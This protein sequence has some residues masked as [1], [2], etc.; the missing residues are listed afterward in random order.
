MENENLETQLDEAVATEQVEQAANTTNTA[1]ELENNSN[2][3]EQEAN[4]AIEEP[5]TNAEPV[6]EEI[7]EP[8]TEEKAAEIVEPV[9]KEPSPPPPP[10]KPLMPVS[11]TT[12]VDKTA[13]LSLSRRMLRSR[14]YFMLI[15]AVLLIALGGL[16]W[17]ILASNEPTIALIVG[18]S[19]IGGGLLI[20]IIVLL[21]SGLFILPRMSTKATEGRK[22]TQSFTLDIDFIKVTQTTITAGE[23]F[24]DVEKTETAT[25]EWQD[26]KKVIQNAQYYFLLLG[27]NLG[28]ILDKNKITDGTL[29]DLERL[30]QA[31]TNK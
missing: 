28:I 24:K 1:N 11:L 9:K 19:L 31:K 3:N 7:V 13:V 25:Y 30:V 22:K 17:G 15:P 26:I 5:T 4:S 6:E 21:T 20:P 2:T 14:F 27:T 29:D 23:D 10:P 18:L 8:A 16:L 12:T